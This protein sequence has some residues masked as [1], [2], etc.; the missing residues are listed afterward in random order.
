M[1]KLVLLLYMLVGVVL[2][3]RSQA[4]INMPFTQNP[5]RLK[6]CFSP[7]RSRAWSWGPIW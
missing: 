1:K 6:V 4:V 2:S 3:V 5:A 7:F